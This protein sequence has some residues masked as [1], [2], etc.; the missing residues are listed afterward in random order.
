MQYNY[1]T[2]NIKVVYKM[3]A[4]KQK[5][6]QWYK[7]D[8][9]AMIYPP[10]THVMRSDMFRVAVNLKE[11]V[12]PKKLEEAVQIAIKRFPTMA[13]KLKKGLFWCY[14]E[15]NEE[16]VPVREEH[17]RPCSNINFTQNNNYCFQVLYYNKRISLEMFHAVTDGTGALALLKEILFNYFKIGHCDIRN[18]LDKKYKDMFSYSE[19]EDSYMKYY[20]NEARQVEFNRIK[21]ARKFSGT[22]LVC[23]GNLISHGMVNVQNFLH[24]TRKKGVTITTYL[25]GLY[26]MAIHLSTEQAPKRRRPISIFVPV[27]LRKIFPSDSMRNFTYFIPVRVKVTDITSI[28]DILKSVKSQMDRGLKKNNLYAPIHYNVKVC[29]SFLFRILPYSLKSPIFKIARGIFS[30]WSMTSMLSNLGKIQLP[31]ELEEHVGWFEF[32]LGSANEQYLNMAVCSF[33]DR[34]IISLSR[35]MIEKE[36]VENFFMLIEEELNIKVERYDNE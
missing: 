25:I 28:D 30:D 22:P 32:I 36:V 9:A 34:M 14:L 35:N 29:N 2:S 13:V 27:N 21:P 15:S 16:A 31:V 20:N 8:N 6:T 7:L 23:K 24:H 17:D 11:D 10:T 4:K 5:H 18:D 33:K 26:I 19:L 1:I 12:N 3:T